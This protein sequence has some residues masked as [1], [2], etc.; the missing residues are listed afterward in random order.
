MARGKKDWAFVRKRC[1]TTAKRLFDHFDRTRRNILKDVAKEFYPLGV[2]GLEKGVEELS[3][4]SPYDE[5]NKLLTTK[6]VDRVRKGAAGFHGNLTSPAKRWFRLARPSFVADGEG[7]KDGPDQTLDRLTEAV[8][9]SFRRGNVY[10]SLPKLYEHVIC[11][12]FGCMLVTRDAE[13][14]VKADTLRIGTYALGVDD[15]GAVCRVA[16]RFSWTA[17]QILTRFGK[18][19]CTEEMLKAA[20]EG[21]QR[22]RWT[23][24][25]LV[26]PN[27][28]GG[29]REYDK[30]AKQLKLSS[31]MVYRSVYWLENAT[32]D[33]PQAG[34]LE[35]S[36]FTVCPIVAPRLDYE[37]GD[38]YGRGRGMDGL[39]LARGLQS[40]QYDILRISGN[41]AEPAVVASSEFKEN[42]LKLNRGA[43]NYA[44]F[45][46]TRQA[47]VMP[48]LP[49]QPSSDGARQDRIDAEAELDDLFFVSAFAAIDSLKAQKGVKTATEID[50][51]VREN[52]EKL[53]PVVTNF[54]K[55]L[56]DPL[57]TAVAKYTLAAGVVPMT[58]EDIEGLRGLNVEYVSPIHLAAKQS[59]ISS[60][61]AFLGAIEPL[62]EA[63]PQVMDK[64]DSDAIVDAYAEMYGTPAKCLRK[65]D[66]VDAARAAR[67]AA[68]QQA[69][70]TERAAALAKGAKDMGGVPVDEGHLGGALMRGLQGEG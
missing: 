8:E 17:E 29:M 65:K 3:D 64:L 47:L 6:P 15:T 34:V 12:G 1:A 20:E 53:N 48:A 61:T 7:V 22:R 33:Q 9:W 21:D 30:V 70:E 51:L 38:V 57:V 14:I 68:A 44:R 49:Q 50:A 31:D 62:A 42:G 11:M 23:V 56:L 4:E 41:A 52:M 5:S 28:T 55:E 59:R 19:G 2:A 60:L 45:G 63:V 16:R 67:A 46:E 32:D 69:I 24:V 54:D 10:K 25:N 43:V 58:P 37:L 39:D 35:A 40:F 27:A 26:E 36:G 66:E 13:R 18:W